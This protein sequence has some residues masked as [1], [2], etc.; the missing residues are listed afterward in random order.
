M[1]RVVGV[2]RGFFVENFLAQVFRSELAT[3]MPTFE[4]V[5]RLYIFHTLTT[6]TTLE[7]LENNYAFPG[8]G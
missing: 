7:P 5:P 2:D 8:Q 6:L 3:V 1:V 4:F